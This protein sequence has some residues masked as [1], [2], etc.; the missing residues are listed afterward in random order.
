M[1]TLMLVLEYH[2]GGFRGWAAQPG[3]RTVEG[4]LSDALATVLGS[5]PPLSVAGR[6]DTGV[7]ATGQVVGFDADAEPE[8]LGR[9]LNGVLPRD[10]AVVSAEPAPDGFDARRDARSRT[11][12]YRVLVR[13][14]PSPF[15]RDRALWWP[16]PLDETALA[17]CAAAIVGTHDFT[18]FTP[19]QTEHVRFE[20][21]VLR[22]EWRRVDDVLE[23]WIEADT[24]MRHMVR[25]LVGTMLE[26][27]GGRR[28]VQSLAGLLA[29]APRASAG[30][31]A[32]P[33]GLCLE[34]VSY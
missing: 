9:S 11:Y 16:H 17:Q 2:G 34:S 20:R 27:A 28:D 30:P 29:G 23:F 25:V 32:E 33:Q 18:A 8:R 10:V 21:D 13:A 14:A 7:H 12:R 1:P 5:P 15:E 6:T 4:T 22:G 31:T 24:F 19:T 26:I 3:L